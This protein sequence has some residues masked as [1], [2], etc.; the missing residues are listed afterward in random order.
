MFTIHSGTTDTRG[1]QL[2]DLI[3]ISSFA[4]I[5]TDSPTRLP[6]NADNSFYRFIIGI[7]QLASPRPN[8]R[9]TWL[10]AQII[11][12]SLSD[13][14]QLSPH[15]PQPQEDWLDRI[16]GRDRTQA[17]LSSSCNWLSERWNVVA[18]ELIPI[19]FLLEDVSYIRNKLQWKSWPWWRSEMTYTSRTRPAPVVDNEWWDHQSDIGSHHS[20]E[21]IRWEH[22]PQDRQHQV[23][24]VD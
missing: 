2:A 3:S 7:S 18:S 15:L 1:N 6:G 16:H 5:N 17:E 9:R 22:W 23:V 20:P 19:I 13:Y 10:G 21:R 24:A 11:C 8:G 12:P 14:R 4:V